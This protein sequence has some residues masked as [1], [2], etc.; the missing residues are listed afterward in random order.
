MSLVKPRVTLLAK[1]ASV[2]ARASTCASGRNTSIRSP[3][4]SRVGKHT[5]APRISYIRL[6]WVSWQPFGLPVVPEV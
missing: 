4:S 1:H 6:E 3:L 5:L 2:I